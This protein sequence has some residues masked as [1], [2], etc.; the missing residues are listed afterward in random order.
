MLFEALDR[1]VLEKLFDYSITNMKTNVKIARNEIF[2]NILNDK[3]GVDLAL[4]LTLGIIHMSF[5]D[6]FKLR[7]NRVLNPAEN[8]ELLTITGSK[9]KQLKEAIFKC[10]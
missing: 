1:E 8:E 6:G 7:H 10:G 5:M 9:L 3:D 2:R 4:G